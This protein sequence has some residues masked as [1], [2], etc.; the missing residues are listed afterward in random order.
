MLIPVGPLKARRMEVGGLLLAATAVAATSR[1]ATAE[2]RNLMAAE[3]V[4][5]GVAPDILSTAALISAAALVPPALLLSLVCCHYHM[6]LC[7]NHCSTLEAAAQCLW[8]C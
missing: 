8:P 2:E 5:A 7:F 3:A 4:N 1:D 6:R